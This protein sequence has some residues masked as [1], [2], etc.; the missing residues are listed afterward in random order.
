MVALKMYLGKFSGKDEAHRS[1]DFTG[2][3]GLLLVVARQTDG[4]I[5]HAIES[6]VDEG[7]HDGHGALGDASFGV[8][9][10]QHLHKKETTTPRLSF[11]PNRIANVQLSRTNL[12]DVGVEGL[13]ALLAALLRVRLLVALGTDVGA[14]FSHGERFEGKK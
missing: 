4:L 2:S 7:V 6:V 9:L 10:L 12:V 11:T 8:D 13:H 1:L 14:A 5:S 3:E